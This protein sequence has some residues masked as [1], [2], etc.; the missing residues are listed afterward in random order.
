MKI[1]RVLAI[2]APTLVGVA[3]IATVSYAEA[4]PLKAHVTPDDIED[5]KVRLAFTHAAFD[6]DGGQPRASLT[7]AAAEARLEI[8]DLKLP[9][10]ATCALEIA[11]DARVSVVEYLDGGQGYGLTGQTERFPTGVSTIE[12]IAEPDPTGDYMYRIGVDK[13]AWRLF[14]CVVEDLS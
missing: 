9:A 5:G 4:P 8:D 6:V 2:A 12:F 10:L 13:G 11:A 1:L 3:S 7:H 14:S